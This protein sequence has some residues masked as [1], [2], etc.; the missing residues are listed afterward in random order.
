MLKRQFLMVAW[1]SMTIFIGYFIYAIS[2]VFLNN[3]LHE[4]IINVLISFI[5]LGLSIVYFKKAKKVDSSIEVIESIYKH[6]NFVIQN[7]VS[8]YRQQLIFSE[9]AT[10]LGR[11]KPHI[12][13]FKSL[14]FANLEILVRAQPFEHIVEDSDGNA[15]MYI[16]IKG[17]RAPTFIVYDQDYRKIGEIKQ[18]L[19]KSLTDYIFDINI[20]D[21]NFNVK[22]E[23]L[24]RDLFV[25]GI[26]KVD[27]TKVPLELTET[28]KTI[29]PTVY[30]IEN[31]L[32]S[33]K[34]KMGLAIAI[35]YEML[36]G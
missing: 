35:I 8:Y 32:N 25:E 9:R 5:F 13:G 21:Q 18:Q 1:I 34:G 27:S 17:F 7:E 12:T 31:N 10:F 33:E 14:F 29:T 26:M 28:F 24:T 36:R 6:Q 20:E 11:Y 16:N 3:H 2:N 22:S 30:E 15:V 4:S 19:F 23:F